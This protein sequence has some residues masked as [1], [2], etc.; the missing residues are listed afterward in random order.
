MLE[1]AL[2]GQAPAIA[3]PLTHLASHDNVKLAEEASGL[4]DQMEPATRGGYAVHRQPEAAISKTKWD[5]QGV[6]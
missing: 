3:A 5:D 2:A 1:A 4:L 6:G